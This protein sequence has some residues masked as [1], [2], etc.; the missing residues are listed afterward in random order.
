MNKNQVEEYLKDFQRN[1][2]PQLIERTLPEY[3]TKKITA[4]IGPR[5]AGKTSIIYLI[6]M[7][8]MKEGAKKS[9]LLYLNF[10]DLRLSDVSFKEIAE[11]ISTHKK[12]FNSDKPILFLDEPQL[13]ENWE[14][15]VRSLYDQGYSIFISGSS[16]KLLSKEIHTSLRGRSL[17]Y[18]ILPF[19]F[20]E[21]LKAKKIVYGQLMSSDEK[22]KLL[23]AL[24]EYLKYGGFPETSIQE[25]EEIKLKILNE[26]FELAL[27]K[28]IVE[29]YKICDSDNIRQFIKS[30]LSSF[31]KEISINKIYNGISSQGRKTSKDELYTYPSMLSDALFAFFLPKFSWSIQKRE[32]VSKVYLN[33]TG[34]SKLVSSSADN[35]KL[36]ENTVFLELIR[37][38]KPFTELSFWKSEQMHYE[39]DFVIKEKEKITQLIQACYELNDE[40]KPREIRALLKAGKELKCDNL[41]IITYDYEGEETAEWYGI[42]SK[43]KYIP[44]WKWLIE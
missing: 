28:D 7:H 2:F 1:D 37:R 27:Y 43:I 23:S 15:A 32:P 4:I 26:Y 12:L 9:D 22:I 10:E 6:M 13:I 14:R 31:S 3:W 44:L 29:R 16:S 5:R 8:L 18:L 38:Q 40:T 30:I 11:V 19:S 34:F 17:S 33:D 36:I 21:Y 41:T 39:V 42:K 25:K 35:G 24:D 20:N